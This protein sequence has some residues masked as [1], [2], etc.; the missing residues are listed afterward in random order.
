MTTYDNLALQALLDPSKARGKAALAKL[1]KH[2]EGRHT[3]PDCGSQGPHE[4]YTH[5]GAKEFACSS[6]GMQHAVSPV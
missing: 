1:G 2:A 3:C 4:T 6:C 5:M